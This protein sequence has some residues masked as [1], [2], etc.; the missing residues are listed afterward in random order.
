[1]RGLSARESDVQPWQMVYGHIRVLEPDAAPVD[2]EE[3]LQVSITPATRLTS[4]GVGRLNRDLAKAYH[5]SLFLDGRF[6]G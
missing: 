6:V 2:I 1:M 3:P 5:V 4:G